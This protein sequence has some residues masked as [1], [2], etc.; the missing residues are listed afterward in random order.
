MNR[1][2]MQ[3]LRRAAWVILTSLL[4]LTVAVAW[5]NWGDL[6]APPKPTSAA[7]VKA[8]ETKIEQGRY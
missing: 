5:D 4:V 1:P 3:P 6:L 2:G 7:V 8:P